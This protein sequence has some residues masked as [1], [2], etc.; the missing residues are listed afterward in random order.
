MA[1]ARLEDLPGF[2]RRFRIS[3]GEA[4][5]CCDIEDDYHCMSVVIHHDGA[6]ATSVE[7]RMHRAPWTTCPGAEAKLCETFTGLA[8]QAFANRG[9]KTAN[10]T[11]LYDLAVLAA[12][13]ALDDQPTIYDILV[14]D[15]V[16][17]MRRA[18]LRKDG[19]KIMAWAEAG[20]TIRE[21]DELAGTPLFEM[22]A[23]IQS[24]EPALQEAA[25]L[26]R[27][28][29]LLA[30]GRSIPLEQQSDATRMP[31]NCYTFQ[32]ERR[33]QARRVGEVHDFSRGVEQPLEQLESAL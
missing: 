27:W 32:P 22:Q 2:R 25:R 13:H 23:W 4:S 5:V 20:L 3:P 8:L 18:E 10:C 31:A 28:G 26:L 12:N 11:H 21:P 33:E 7:A 24:L 19:R 17:G 14:S 29:N 15:P 30:N 16:D 1:S 9:E 6:V